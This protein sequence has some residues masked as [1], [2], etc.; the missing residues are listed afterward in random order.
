MTNQHRKRRAREQNYS[1]RSPLQK[2]PTI[3]GGWSA[4]GSNPDPDV[5]IGTDKSALLQSTSGL[6]V[7][8]EELCECQIE[9]C[10]P[11]RARRTAFELLRSLQDPNGIA[12]FQTEDEA[13]RR[14]IDERDEREACC[15]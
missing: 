8:R 2:M 4:T 5:R 3:L 15:K 1:R 12:I 11:A 9:L 6:P 7:T 13:S 14:K 10:L